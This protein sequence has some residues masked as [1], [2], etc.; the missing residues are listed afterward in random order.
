MFEHKHLDGEW[1]RVLPATASYLDKEILEIRDNVSP[2]CKPETSNRKQ[3]SVIGEQLVER[4]LP[5]E[6]VGDR[7]AYDAADVSWWTRVNNPP[8]MGIIAAFNEYLGGKHRLPL[9]PEQNVVAYAGSGEQVLLKGGKYVVTRGSD[10]KEI[11]A[12]SLLLARQAYYE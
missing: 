6:S 9:I 10:N 12:E 11:F 2:K 5:P 3:Y 4:C 8:H 1:N 7:W